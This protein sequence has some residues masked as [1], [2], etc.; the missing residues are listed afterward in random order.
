LRTLLID[1]DILA[2]QF[3]SSAQKQAIKWSPDQTEVEH[4]DIAD[5]TPQVDSWLDTIKTK[6]NADALIVCLSCATVDGWR[7]QLLPTYKAGRGEKPVLLAQVKQHLRST[8]RTFERPTLEADDVMGILATHPTLV[9]GKKCIVSIDKDMRSIPGW[10][11][12][13]K[14]MDKPEFITVEEADRT[15]MMQTLTGDTCD[16]YKGCPGIGAVKAAALLDAENMCGTA[17]ER[18]VMR[19][20]SKGL[21]E[22]DALIQARVARIC[23]STEYDFLRKE[24]RLWNPPCSNTAS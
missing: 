8:Y 15:H 24:V 3:A 5:V 11:F 14:K 18:V 20:V 1:A 23:R 17:W 10:L 21:T 7:V 4:D 6:L 13:W 16:N 12:D 2:Y 9:Q 19:Y 22:A